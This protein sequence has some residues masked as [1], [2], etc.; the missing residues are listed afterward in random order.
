[1]AELLDDRRYATF[2]VPISRSLA[3][4]VDSLDA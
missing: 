1:M 4:A 2:L 3:S